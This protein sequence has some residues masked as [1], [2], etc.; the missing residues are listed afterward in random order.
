MNSAILFIIFNRSYETKRVFEVIKKVQPKRLYVAADGPRNEDE[1]S[2]CMLARE[3]I[4]VDWEC[5]VLTRFNDKNLGCKLNVSSAIDWFFQHEEQGIILEDDVIP[6]EDFFIYCDEMLKMYKNDERIGAISGVNFVP[7]MVNDISTSYYFSKHI[8]IWGWATWRRVWIKYD[9]HMK[10]WANIS[11][12]R[13]LSIKNIGGWK[14]RSYWRRIF[15]S[16]SLGKIDTWDYQLVYVFFKNQYLSIVPKYNLV[17][18]IGFNNNAT[19]TK[20]RK[21][22]HVDAMKVVKSIFPL[23]HPISVEASDIADSA[24]NEVVFKTTIFKEI[25]EISKNRIKKWLM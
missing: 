13:E 17:K 11:V 21:P 25:C 24:V 2:Q 18:N 20:G 10:S 12:D 1:I 6:S 8:H 4:A 16:T 3:A 15:D 14:S 23:R 22:K 7:N 5:E 19:H 9:V